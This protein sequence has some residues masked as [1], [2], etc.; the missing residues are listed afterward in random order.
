MGHQTTS[1]LAVALVRQR[2]QDRRQFR[3]RPALLHKLHPCSLTLLSR[4]LY[5]LVATRRLR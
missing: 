4:G 1:H 2:G 5:L 3:V